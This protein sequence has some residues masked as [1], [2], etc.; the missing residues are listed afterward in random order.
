METSRNQFERGAVDI[1]KSRL[2]A[3]EA[4]L[5]ESHENLGRLTSQLD[6]VNQ[7]LERLTSYDSL[8]GL[9][10]RTLFYDQLSSF[11]AIARREKR[12]LPLLVL[13]VNA[14]KDV[15]DSLGHQAGDNVLR[16]V[17]KR[18]SHVLRDSD[19]AARL[20]GN[21]F[22]IVL[23]TAKTADGAIVVAQKIAAAVEAPIELNGHR[24]ILGV[25]IGISVFPD[26]GMD[27]KGIV[28]LA[29]LA[30]EEAKRSGGG[31]VACEPEKHQAP[32]GPV[33]LA[34][35]VREAI[36]KN[37]LILHYQPKVAMKDGRV[38]GAEALVRWDHPEQ[39]LIYP[40][41][42][43]PLVE[44][45]GL[46]NSLTL[47]VLDK[48]LAQAR[49]WRENGNP[50]SI[51]V[52][53]SPRALHDG[54]LPEHISERLKFHAVPPENLI[55]EITET[56][57]MI[58]ADKAMEVVTE[59]SALGV[60]IA[61]DDFG[62]GYSSLAY[63]RRLPAQEIKIDR[64]FVLSMHNNVDDKTIVRSVIDLARNLGMEVVAEGVES[65][66]IYDLLKEM[67][68]YCAQGYFI[69]RPV[70]EIAFKDWVSNP[71]WEE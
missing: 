68:C 6:Q 33:M 58:D 15:N 57:I 7:D 18:I 54:R 51:A 48:A 3:L 4:E 62:T 60:G 41:N 25:S 17:A 39:G 13:D 38:I 34:G 30:M 53:L 70:D 55:L 36:D 12:K 1:S 16:E 59:L 52:N 5:T 11:I 67:D 10:N 32:V 64:S 46:I 69:S 49:I 22:G 26:N 27:E 8:T 42:F 65:R 21:E 23:P 24:L 63:L 61:I 35:D 47:A 28:S 20:G 71:T 2:T 66:E 9:A 50:L 44:R 37:E 14:F 31:F 19:S 56:A 43:I 40:D 45:T 29:L